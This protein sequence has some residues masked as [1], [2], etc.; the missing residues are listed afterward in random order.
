MFFY[1][2]KYALQHTAF[3]KFEN[4]E[5]ELTEAL[6]RLEKDSKEALKGRFVR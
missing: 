5:H 2:N 4:P 1:K 6:E 3:D